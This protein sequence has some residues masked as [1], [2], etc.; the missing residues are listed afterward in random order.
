MCATSPYLSIDDGGHPEVLGRPRD[1]Q[2][3]PQEDENGQHQRDDRGRDHVVKDDD[4]VADQLGVSRQDVT[5]GEGQ[6]Q[7]PVLRGVE[8]PT[9]KQLVDG[10]RSATRPTSEIKRTR[11]RTRLPLQAWNGT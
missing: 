8:L 7:E 10:V 4:E 2:H 3:G 6:F 11:F 5:R 1:G 9:L